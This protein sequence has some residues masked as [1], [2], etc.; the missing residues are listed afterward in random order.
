MTDSL[1]KIP[2]GPTNGN[3]VYFI[4]VTRDIGGVP[5]PIYVP[6]SYDADMPTYVATIPAS[7]LAANKNHAS[8]VNLTGSGKTVR[9]HHI[10]ATPSMSAAIVGLQVTLEVHG[11]AATGPTAG[12]VI[13]IRN[14]DT[15][16]DALPAQIEVRSNPTATPAANWILASGVVNTEETSPSRDGQASIFKKQGNI[17][18]LILRENQGLL[19]KQTAL[20]GAGAINLHIVFLVD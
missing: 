4:T 2:V 7:T 1:N 19:I 11:V 17:S 3:A 10:Y 18:S 20:A 15:D 6:T 16:D 12:T 13:T 9:I 5:T 8:I 14:H